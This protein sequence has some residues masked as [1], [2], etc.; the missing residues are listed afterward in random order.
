MWLIRKWSIPPRSRSLNGFCGPFNPPGWCFYWWRVQWCRI[1]AKK[2][3]L[4]EEWT[5]STELSTGS[6]RVRPPS[7]VF[8]LISE[9]VQNPSPAPAVPERQRSVG[10][11]GKFS[12]LVG[13]SLNRRCLQSAGDVWELTSL[14]EVYYRLRPLA[15]QLVVKWKVL[16]SIFPV[17][18]CLRWNCML[19]SSRFPK[20]LQ[21]STWNCTQ[22]ALCLCQR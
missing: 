3:L 20:Q 10:H 16:F 14:L 18:L 22:F 19:S 11:F 7:A 1:S 8:C 2:S 12:P 9:W 6:E 21:C 13:G 4:T 5:L 17:C 15:S